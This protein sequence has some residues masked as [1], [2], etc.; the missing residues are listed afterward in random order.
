MNL[1]RGYQ[2]KK[3]KVECEMRRSLSKARFAMQCDA[4]L[5]FGRG[6]VSCDELACF[7]LSNWHVQMVPE[8]G[9]GLGWS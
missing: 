5:L 6:C 1:Q 8:A 4:F 7:R 3:Y 2:V 9:L